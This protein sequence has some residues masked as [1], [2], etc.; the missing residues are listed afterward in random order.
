MTDGTISLPGD[1][2]KPVDNWAGALRRRLEGAPPRVV[3]LVTHLASLDTARPKQT[4]K[5]RTLGLLEDRDARAAVYDGVRL[6]TRCGPGRVPVYSASWDDRGLVGHPNLGVARGFLWA[7]TLTG[8]TTVLADLAAVGRR[9]GGNL[10]EFSPCDQLMD[11]LI[12]ALAEW[13]DPAALETLWALHRDLLPGRPHDRLYARLLP[14]AADR[15]GIPPERQAERTVPAHGLRADG[16]VAFGGRFGRGVHWLLATFSA[17]VTVE[18]AHTVSLVYADREVE[19]RTVHPFAAPHGFK[20]RHHPES[21][22]WMRRY[23]GRVLA[24]VHGE[25]ER[26]RRLAGE[27]R[28]WTFE[29]W[30]HL[31]RDHPVTG[32]VSRGL[33]WEFRD[34]GGGRETA[35]PTAPGGALTTADGRTPPAPDGKTLVRL[36]R[37][38]GAPPDEVRAWREHFAG[39]GVRP[40]FGQGLEAL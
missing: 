27:D 18:D 28:D 29:E 37:A 21:V 11:A 36:W 8:D 2:V 39:A 15:L 3:E 13:T 20:K 23:A 9:I 40:S 31:Y 14:K 30:A 16:S 10:P 38:E 17:L 25:R 32:V 33:V 12:H 5:R 7:A 6:L 4:W 19:K 22:E 35:R 26:L 24:A 1:A 34:T